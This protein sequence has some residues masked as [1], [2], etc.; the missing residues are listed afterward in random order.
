MTVEAVKPV[1]TK[2]KIMADMIFPSRRIFFMPATAEEIEK[3]TS[4]TITVKS[5]FRNTSPSGLNN[6]ASFL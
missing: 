4:G 5:R 6:T 2:I 3:K 1:R